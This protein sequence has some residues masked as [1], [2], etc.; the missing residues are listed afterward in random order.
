VL[1]LSSSVASPADLTLAVAD[2]EGAGFA[3]RDI[4]VQLQIG[5]EAPP[6]GRITIAQ[7]DLPPPLNTLS[8]LSLDCP[9]LRISS[10]R[11]QCTG[12][13]MTLPLDG[14]DSAGSSLDFTLAYDGS[15]QMQWLALR[16]GDATMDVRLQRTV[17]D[18]W[19]VDLLG[20][21]LDLAT[22]SAW[23]PAGAMVQGFANLEAQ[24][25]WSAEGAVRATLAAELRGASGSSAEG[26]YAAEDVLMDVAARVTG[27]PDSQLTFDVALRPRAGQMYLE[28]IFLDFAEQS[29]QAAF[30]GTWEPAIRR[31]LITEMNYRD[32]GAIA[33]QARG[34][35]SLQGEGLLRI[36]RLE[37]QLPGAYERYA[38]P[39][40]IGGPL[41][42]LTTQGS[43]NGSAAWNAGGLDSVDL[44]LNHLSAQDSEDRLAM[45]DVEGEIHWHRTQSP[46]ASWLSWSGGRVLRLDF[47]AARVPL[48]ASGDRLYVR[49]EQ[50]L[51]LLDGTVI[52]RN[53]TAS[54]LISGNPDLRLDLE[55]EPISLPQL[56]TALD[57]PAMNGSLAGQLPGVRYT[58][59]EISTGGTLHVAVFDGDITVDALRIE[60][61]LSPLPRLT[62]D[63]RLQRLDLEPLTSTFAFGQITGRLD[64]EILGLRLL[65]W[66]PSAFDA[67]LYTSP[68]E[69]DRQRISQRAID[70]LAALSGG[71]GALSSGF[72]RFFDSFNYEEI[73]ISCRLEREVCVMNGAGPAN[74]GYYLVRGRGLPRIN[75]IGSATR[76]SWPALLQQL[77]NLQQV[78]GAEI[79]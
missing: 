74:G 54:G 12:A 73:G 32:E 16:W 78:E 76:V 24:A 59:R 79:R 20:A 75:V 53:L 69:P 21:D 38:H 15:L 6:S 41:A 70:N 58:Q 77:T 26:E 33:V 61:L 65:N 68:T 39:F 3:L 36:E 18:A 44:T 23:V 27:Q 22:A 57:W 51:P 47:G 1:W 45:R 11:V 37:G 55:L 34:A 64:G 43:F 66:R 42:S 71:A 13:A 67:R 7:A 52:F 10:R 72:L 30:V 5:A 29:L 40:L 4:S 14:F 48:E 63:I 50:R 31:L 62:A 8:D 25:D 35:V 19:Q 28:P 9:T 56:T 60:E 49:G 46:P 17:D 2:I